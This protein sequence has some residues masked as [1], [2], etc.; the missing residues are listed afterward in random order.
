MTGDT[1]E[2]TADVGGELGDMI[3]LLS[4]KEFECTCG[5][6]FELGDENDFV[7]YLHEGGLADKVGAKWWLFTTCPEC[8]YQWSWVKIENRLRRAGVL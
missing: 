6:G 7:G 2:L 1:V 3:D 8:E 5:H 4:G